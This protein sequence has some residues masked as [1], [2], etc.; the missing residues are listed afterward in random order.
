MRS[1]ASPDSL[2]YPFSCPN[3]LHLRWMF[4][5]WTSAML[6]AT[7]NNLTLNT[8]KTK[9]VIFHDSRRSHSVQ[10]PPLLPGVARDFAL[11]VLGVTLSSNLS[12][13]DHIRRVISDSAQSLYALRV[14]RHHGMND[15]GLQTVF[16][17]VVVS[18]LMYAS[19]AWRGFATATDLKR[20][21][22]FLPRCKRCGYC[23][24]DL[25]DFEE[26]LDE[27]DNRLFCKILNNSTHTLHTLLPPQSIA[28]QHY[29]L[30]R[31]NHDRQLPT[32]TSHQCTRALYKDCY[33]TCTFNLYV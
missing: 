6:W 7:E 1:S 12:A 2:D 4:P 11:K 27:S 19:P 18:R 28:S 5:D 17:A 20:V 24:S 13:S 31:L 8:L 16:R 25:P 26:L 29:H 3:S 30:R 15:A 23:S 10:S 33:W 14:L 21:D 9:E 32:Q 22:T